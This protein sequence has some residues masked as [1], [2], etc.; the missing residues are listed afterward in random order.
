[1]TEFEKFITSDEYK[2]IDNLIN[3]WQWNEAVKLIF[4]A[5]QNHPEWIPVT[6]RLPTENDDIEYV[7]GLETVNVF[8][9]DGKHRDIGCFVLKKKC[10]TD[11]CGYMVDVEVKNIIAWQPLSKV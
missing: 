2:K 7:P 4:K 1:M 3:N 9:S 8:V 5:G 6:E 11:P 10:F